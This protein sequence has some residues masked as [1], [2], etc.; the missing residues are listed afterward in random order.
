M[1]AEGRSWRRWQY[2]RNSG[3]NGGTDTNSNA[4]TDGNADTN[5][6]ASTNGNADTDTNTNGNANTSSN[7]NTN[8]YS[9]THSGEFTVAIP[10]PILV[11]GSNT[12]S[13][14]WVN[15]CTYTAHCKSWG[16]KR[17]H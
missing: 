8:S 13:N 7:A 11:A 15:G 5:S 6:N 3:A 9:S 2:G 14:T 16:C 12:H 1:A 17:F 4:R 10:I